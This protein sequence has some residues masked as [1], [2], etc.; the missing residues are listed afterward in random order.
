MSSSLWQRSL[1]EFQHDVETRSTPGC[2]AAAALNGCLGLS[3]ILK[4]VRLYRDD[5]QAPARDRLIADGDAL[6]RLLARAV[7]DDAAAFAD[8]LDAQRRSATTEA[9]TQD[10]ESA[11]NDAREASIRIPLQAAEH[12]QSALA[13]AVDAQSLTSP[14]L[15]SDTRAGSVMLEAAL[16]ALLIGVEANLDAQPDPSVRRRLE[17]RCEKL[18]SEARRL[19][20]RLECS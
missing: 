8:Y 1:A 9:Q 3:L 12:C 17:L 18:R 6:Q 2:G 7:D 19:A 20:G 4:G 15:Q 11:L 5:D 14:A 10:R 13:L 16:N